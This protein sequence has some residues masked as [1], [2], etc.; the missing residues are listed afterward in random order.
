LENRLHWAGFRED[1]PQILA[2]SDVCVHAATAGE[3]VT[4]VVREALAMAKPV[5]VT[6]VGGNC[7]LVRDSQTGLLV[8]PRDPEALAQGM[9]R[10]VAA[11]TEAAALGRAGRRLVEE[12]FSHEVKAARME[13]LYLDILQRKGCRRT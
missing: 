4:G 12:H 8:P 9:L 1:L 6:D 13:Q 5:V 2:A 10:L 3:G 7:E 11:P